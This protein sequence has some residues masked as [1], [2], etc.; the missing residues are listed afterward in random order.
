M[1]I[2]SD[3]VFTGEGFEPA[4]I[5]IDDCVVES[6]ASWDEAG[7]A[8]AVQAAIDAGAM[9]A[10]GSVVIPG[11]IDL[12]FHGAAGADFC[13]G[14]VEAVR[15]MARY[16]ASCGVTAICPATMTFPEEVLT[17]AMEAASVFEPADDE[18]ALIGINME[19]P[20]ISPHKVG[21][22]NPAYVQKADANM[23]RRL[24]L[25]A[26]GLIRLVDVAPEEDGALDFIREM[27]D[28]VRISVAHTCA[29]YDTA[30]AAYLAGARQLTHTCNAMPGLHHR[31]P[32]P[33]AAAHDAIELDGMD[34]VYVELIGDGKHV[35][36]PMVRFLFDAFDGHVV[37]ISDTMRAAGLEDGTYEFGGQQ[38]AVHDSLAWVNGD[39]IAGS[40]TNVGECLR[41]L[42]CE[43]QVDPV[44]AVRAVTVN[45]ATAL[46]EELYRG[47]I[48]EGKM[49][50]LVV[51]NPDFT[52]RDVMV[53]GKFLW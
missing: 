23:I 20:F 51:L 11:M 14:T 46:G 7:G 5:A 18:A 38:V 39:T 16:E 47:S 32:G 34:D 30:H 42:V 37:V 15:T 13:D 33:I 19:G 4:I 31:E 53:R 44:R 28:E 12:H 22:Q 48:E 2:V 9:D 50:D 25:A 3:K 8:Q 43:M 35:Q 52:V 21:G 24:Q 10:R 1:Q 40:V 27:S 41:R 49:A 26:S 17:L 36:A 29:D 6:V 45:P